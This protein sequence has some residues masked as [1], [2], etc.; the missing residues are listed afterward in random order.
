MTHRTYWWRPTV[1]LQSLW[2]DMRLYFGQQHHSA[3][4][5]FFSL[6]FLSVSLSLSHTHT[7]THTLLKVTCNADSDRV[8]SHIIVN[9]QAQHPP[10]SPP[11]IPSLVEWSSL[12]R[13][14]P[15]WFT[16]RKMIW[17][18]K[19]DL[20]YTH[21]HVTNRL[22]GVVRVLQ[23]EG[24]TVIHHTVLLILHFSTLYLA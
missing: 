21:K 11:A 20:V 14:S 24:S 19:C 3:M 5:I 13:T 2:W 4:L 1:T 7:H 15:R 22:V 18:T 6:E 8:I 9:V 17:L 10:R 23:G 12:K 16:V